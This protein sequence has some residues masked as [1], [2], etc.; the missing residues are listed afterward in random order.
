[1]LG[2]VV[3][4]SSAPATAGRTGYFEDF[5]GWSA[6]GTFYALRTAGTDGLFVP[7]LYLTTR[8][9]ASSSWPKAV[10]KPGA[11][12]E[13]GCTDRWDMM[14]PDEQATQES[15]MEKASA[16]VDKTKAAAKG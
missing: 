4:A 1:M 15:M 13:T 2:V 5:I 8:G 12:D 11:D 16:F 10:P 6:D 3:L 9:G 14:F 7:V